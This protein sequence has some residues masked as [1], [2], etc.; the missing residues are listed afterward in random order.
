VV[1]WRKI[2][3]S[4]KEDMC[5]SALDLH[6]LYHIFSGFMIFILGYLLLQIFLSELTACL[7]L[8]IG[9]LVISV[10]FEI[11]ENSLRFFIKLK[12]NNVLDSSLNSQC[13]TLCMLIGCI[14]GNMIYVMI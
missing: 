5:I 7:C 10:I 14:I 2:I 8:Y 9:I 1:N 3:G 11:L 4:K 6:S 12:P 13:D